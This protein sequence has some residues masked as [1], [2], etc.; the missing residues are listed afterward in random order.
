LFQIVHC[1]PLKELPKQSA[2]EVNPPSPLRKHAESQENNG[3]TVPVLSRTPTMVVTLRHHTG[4]ISVHSFP[5]KAVPIRREPTEQS[6]KHRPDR[7]PCLDKAVLAQGGAPHYP[8]QGY[9]PKHRLG[10]QNHA[11]QALLF[12]RQ[13][14]PNLWLC[15]FQLV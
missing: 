13:K 1:N 2:W 9:L 4:K 6:Q 11:N 12:M 15:G 7:F 3:Q 8:P 10:T 5:C 14:G